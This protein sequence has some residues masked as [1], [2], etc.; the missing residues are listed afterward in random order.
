MF[1]YSYKNGRLS[2]TNVDYQSKL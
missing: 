2:L 1:K